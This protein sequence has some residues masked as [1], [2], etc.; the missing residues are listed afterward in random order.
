MSETT[1]P[2]QLCGVA[3]EEAE[4]LACGLCAAPH[5]KD[6]WEYAGLCS[7]YGCGGLRAIPYSR[8]LVPQEVHLDESQLTEVGPSLGLRIRRWTQGSLRSP[9]VRALPATLR[10]G[11]TG[12]IVASLAFYFG[13][14]AWISPKLLFHPRWIGH[15]LGYGSGLVGVGLLY[16]LLSPFLATYQHR[17]PLAMTWIAGLAS[18]GCF[19]LSLPGS[20]L[21]GLSAALLA[22]PTGILGILSA[23]TFAEWLFGPYR[24]WGRRLGRASAA[25]RHAVTGGM[26]LTCSL[27]ILTLVGLPLGTSEILEVLSWTLL[28]TV[29]AGHS[30]EVGKEELRKHL[31]AQVEGPGAAPEEEPDDLSPR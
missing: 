13:I 18:V 3:L 15:F 6:C 30:L 24:P 11:F 17:Y 23:A 12:G 2:C 21:F 8:A 16:G 29:A 31:I 4:A 5:H 14:A 22:I 19:L 25:A 1:V 26:F 10:A 7:T 9:G 27:L 20:P 28:A